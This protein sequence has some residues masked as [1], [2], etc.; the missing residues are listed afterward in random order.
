MRHTAF[1][2]AR[3]VL[4]LRF[5]TRKRIEVVS[6]IPRH[7]AEG[8]IHIGDWIEGPDGT[9]FRTLHDPSRND[10]SGSGADCRPARIEAHGPAFGA[11]ADSAPVGA[12]MVRFST[13]ATVADHVAG[14][15]ING[16]RPAERGIS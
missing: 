6:T 10:D 13:V 8:E 2:A 1:A 16:L 12:G 3:V 9:L 15:G 4:E 14:T 5:S 7:G 11:G